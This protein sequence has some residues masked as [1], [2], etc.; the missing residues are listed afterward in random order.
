MACADYCPFMRISKHFF[1]SSPFSLSG[2]PLRKNTPTICNLGAVVHSMDRPFACCIR[3]MLDEDLTTRY[4]AS[5]SAEHQRTVPL[6][7][8]S[9]GHHVASTTVSPGCSVLQS[10]L[11]VFFRSQL[12][13]LDHWI[14]DALGQ[15]ETASQGAFQAGNT[16]FLE[17]W[18]NFMLERTFHSLSGFGP[19]SPF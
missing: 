17:P 8:S 18:F 19:G 11:F 7:F 1:A 13:R 12:L 6:H 5:V 2:G 9:D 4:L 15:N 14:H 10:E 16:E 3:F